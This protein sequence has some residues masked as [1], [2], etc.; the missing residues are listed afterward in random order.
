M[1]IVYFKMSKTIFPL[2]KNNQLAKTRIYNMKNDFKIFQCQHLEFS[3]NFPVW[4]LLGIWVFTWNLFGKFRTEHFRFNSK[5]FLYNVCL[6]FNWK[7]PCGA[8]QQK[9]ECLLVGTCSE[10]N[11]KILSGVFPT[12]LQIIIALSLLGKFLMELS[13]KNPSA[14]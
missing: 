14:C 12:K 13:N 10:F 6:E 5:C 4:N 7:I 9:A 8:F 3:W 11:W 2:C 1:K